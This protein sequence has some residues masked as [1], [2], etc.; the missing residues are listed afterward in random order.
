MKIIVSMLLIISTFVVGCD[1]EALDGLNLKINA[2]VNSNY[3]KD[4]D[5]D[6][7]SSPEK[8][9]TEAS[10]TKQENQSIDKSEVKSNNES[11]SAISDNQSS[12]KVDN[13][14]ENDVDK[15]MEFKEI[16]E[17][18]KA[19]ITAKTNEIFYADNSQLKSIDSKNEK[20]LR[21]WKNIYAQVE[22]ECN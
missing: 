19:G 3:D 21:Q 5:K 8:T 1:R 15:P 13:V 4:K 12:Q 11:S 14:I 2:E 6:K 22:K 18:S 17:C 9:N 16:K 7:N 20:Q 10:I